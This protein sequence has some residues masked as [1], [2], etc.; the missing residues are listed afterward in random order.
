M[1]W[2]NIFSGSRRKKTDGEEATA[3]RKRKAPVKRTTS[4]TRTRSKLPDEEEV[5]EPTDDSSYEDSDPENDTSEESLPQE[6]SSNDD[7]EQWND[8]PAESPAARPSV[9]GSKGN[10]QFTQIHKSHTSSV[11]AP[12]SRRQS[13]SWQQEPESFE[14]TASQSGDSGDETDE[15]RQ[16]QLDSG[17][18]SDQMK[19]LSKRQK[20]E[21][22]KQL[23]DQERARGR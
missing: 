12:H 6:T 10:G 8:E 5:E 11:P 22:K 19:G 17:M 14:E 16:F 1:A 3:K 21:L 9:S 13:P 4:R 20:R 18:T 2:R 15:D 7:Q 23:R